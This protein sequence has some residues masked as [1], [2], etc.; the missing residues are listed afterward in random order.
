MPGI[1][2]P[3]FDASDFT[4]DRPGVFSAEASALGIKPG[5]LPGL[6]EL[7][8]GSGGQFLYVGTIHDG[9][10]VKYR[11]TNSQVSVIIWN[12]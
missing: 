8:V 11:Q 7:N 5:Q 12:T 3:V 6:F 9:G 2:S 4:E 10:G 1:S